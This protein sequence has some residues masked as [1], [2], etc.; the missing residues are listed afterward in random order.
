[1]PIC[2][3]NA[4]WQLIGKAG[5]GCIDLHADK[6]IEEAIKK[7]GLEDF[8]PG[9][10]REALKQLLYALDSEAALNAL[11]RKLIKSEILKGLSVQLQIQDWFTRHPEIANEE[12]NAPVIIIGMP[13]SGTTILHELMQL[14]AD[15]RIPL[16]WEV[17]A[18][19]PPP[20][21]AMYT[22]DSRIKQ[23]KKKLAFS[24]YLM[25]E[26]VKMHRLGAELP[27]ECVAIT[28]NVF[29]SMQYTTIYRIP[30][31]QRWLMNEAD[32]K[33]VYRFHR[34]FLQLLQWRCPGKRWV[35]KSPGH[36]WHLESLLC[37]YPDARLVQTHRDPL[38]I[39]S[40]LA[41]M[42]PTLRSMA[43]NDLEPRAIALEWAECNSEALQES[44]N[45]RKT[46]V[47]KP[48]QVV[49]IRFGD[50]MADP[51]SEV[52]KIY[53]SFDMPFSDEV[54]SKIRT[55]IAENP[56][57]KH[58]GHKHRFEDCGLN[59]EE[60]RERVREYQEYFHVPSEF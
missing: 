45:A 33:A 34:R 53:R 26:V 5:I 8:G 58:G 48:E 20:E 37:E 28:T 60:E 17:D 42:V 59:Y 24:H 7:T 16:Y 25:P 15:N 13:R 55:Y 35:L 31:Y 30:S 43:S 50:F 23:Q 9:P 36:L 39:V 2:I 46:G 1:M 38:K 22:T 12:I 57:D 56:H 4:V 47:I 19:C 11:G 32:M 18:P 3:I 40:S 29:C 21:K 6:L 14:D 10:F 51:T 27:Q 54:A 49:D 41:S 52:E 44:V